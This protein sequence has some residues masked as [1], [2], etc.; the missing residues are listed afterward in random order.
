MNRKPLAT[1]RILD[2]SYTARKTHVTKVT[3]Y[4]VLRIEVNYQLKNKSISRSKLPARAPHNPVWVNTLTQKFNIGSHR[5]SA[6][7]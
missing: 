7:R 2:E 6:H 1:L 5:P 4:G 3:I